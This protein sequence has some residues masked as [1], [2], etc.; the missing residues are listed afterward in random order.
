MEL[1]KNSACCLKQ[2]LEV[3]PYKEAATRASA[4]HLIV[5]AIKSNMTSGA[6]LEKKKH[7]SDFLW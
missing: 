7:L 6:L 2:V 3:T 4:Y 1:V 5:P